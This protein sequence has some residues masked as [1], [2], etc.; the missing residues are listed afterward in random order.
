MDKP[1]IKI[2]H[3]D[4]SKEFYPLVVTFIHSVH[5]SFE[6]VSRKIVDLV[7]SGKLTETTLNKVA[8]KGFIGS[9]K[10]PLIG[11]FA[12][13]SDFQNNFIKIDIDEIATDA[14]YNLGY[15]IEAGLEFSA[16]RMLLISAYEIKKDEIKG[17]GLETDELWQFF[18]HCRNAAAH[19]GRF[20]FKKDEPKFKNKWGNFEIVSDMAGTKLFRDEKEGFVSSGDIVRLLWDI[21]QKFF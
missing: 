1:N 11:K 13:R 9:Q 10:T 16:A 21:E 8:L 15:L 20:Y 18:R 5:G 7:A 19:N 6:L 3:F 17:K 14:F 2:N 4:R 12:L